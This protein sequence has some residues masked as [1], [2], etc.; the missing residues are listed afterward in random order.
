MNALLVHKTCLYILGYITYIFVR[1]VDAPKANL[2]K[3]ALRVIYHVPSQGIIIT[4]LAF[5]RRR[6]SYRNDLCGG[7]PGLVV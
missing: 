1:G 4:I 6:R 3:K 2:L 5:L 7:R